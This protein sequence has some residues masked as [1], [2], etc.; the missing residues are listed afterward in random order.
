[1][2][3]STHLDI[4]EPRR[5]ALPV[6]RQSTV[7]A[8]ERCPIYGL[9]TRLGIRPYGRSQALDTGSYAHTIV[10]I[11]ATGGTRQDG[12]DA[13]QTAFNRMLED[14]ANHPIYGG[15][16]NN[17][18]PDTLADR[19]LDLNKG[20]VSGIIA[21][22][23]VRAA[24]DARTIDVAAS[25]LSQIVKLPLPSISTGKRA[26]VIR[27][28]VNLD[29]VFR[30]PDGTI[31]LWDLKTADA[32]ASLDEVFANAYRRAQTWGY[33][34]GYRVLHPDAQVHGFQYQGVCK[35]SIK[36]KQKQTLD[37]YIAECF[38]WHKGTGRHADK[39]DKRS[40]SPTTRLQPLP[41]SHVTEI[42][43][44][45]ALRLWETH[46]FLRMTTDLS[47]Y[48]PHEQSCHSMGSRCKFAN[49]CDDPTGKTWS[50]TLRSSYTMEPDPL[51]SDPSRTLD[52]R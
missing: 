23:P 4:P 31:W 38:E 52:N 12:I 47:Q 49:F 26:R 25:E 18:S 42:P 36:Q 6:V 20:I 9:F 5:L 1:M 44:Q 17:I 16:V 28:K 45:I 35:P 46:R 8:R 15:N 30:K 13:C 10:R 50:S 32:N 37:D 48:P 14:L 19:R 21:W 43:T 29:L 51:D 27:F 34:R 7:N 39:L 41:M 3:A 11:L 40:A 24:L 22:E 2:L 33:W